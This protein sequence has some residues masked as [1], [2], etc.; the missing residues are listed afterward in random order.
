MAITEGI[1]EAF[2]A[3]GDWS[4]HIVADRDHA[5]TTDG[6][7]RAFVTMG[8]RVYPGRPRVRRVYAS[9]VYTAR[10]LVLRLFAAAKRR[11]AD[12]GPAPVERVRLAAAANDASAGSTRL[13]SFQRKAALSEKDLEVERLA[14]LGLTNTEIGQRLGI[15]QGAASR[16]LE[17]VKDVRSI[18]RVKAR[19]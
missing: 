10:A 6:A 3:S 12:G 18:E 19:P 8:L 13:G 15:G 1:Y 17:R 2:Y 9:D 11:E 4:A 16:I 7:T 5:R 14:A